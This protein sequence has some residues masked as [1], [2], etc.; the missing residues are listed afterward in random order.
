VSG[1]GFYG[2][3][4][5]TIF[6]RLQPVVRVGQLDTDLEGDGSSGDDELTHYDVGLNY[7]IKGPKARLSASVS[8]FDF[9][10]E[11]TQVDLIL[12]AQASF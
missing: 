4:G 12:M 7:Y 10:Q 5:Y 6:D 3:L 2:A 11:P 1:H 9:E 8:I